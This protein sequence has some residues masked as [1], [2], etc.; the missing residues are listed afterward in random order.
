MTLSIGFYW[1]LHRFYFFWISIF[2]LLEHHWR[3]LISRNFHLVYQNWYRITFTF[4]ISLS[5]IT[6]WRRIVS[7]TV[8]PN[9][10]KAVLCN[11]LCCILGIFEICSRKIQIF[12]HQL[13]K[14]LHETKYVRIIYLFFFFYQSFLYLT[15]NAWIIRY[16][17]KKNQIIPSLPFKVWL[18]NLALGYRFST[19][20][21]ARL[22]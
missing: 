18:I 6:I 13:L 4:A 10:S 17:N 20:R 2:F 15:R 8:Y 3:E 19:I 12:H 14:H 22:S 9:W 7:V 5:F 11:L 1:H 16:R 21:N